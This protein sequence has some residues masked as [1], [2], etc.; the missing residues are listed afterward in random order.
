ML[1][2]EPP[3]ALPGQAALASAASRA[4]RPIRLLALIVLL[5]GC[6]TVA[7]V[8]GTA[9][10]DDVAQLR[11]DVTALQLGFQRLRVDSER[12][13]SQLDTRV[14]EQTAVT[15][16]QAEELSQQLDRLSTTVT[17]LTARLDQ[18]SG[19][20]DAL[21]QRATMQPPPR[22]RAQ[23]A[24]PMQRPVPGPSTAVPA[25][26]PQAIPAPPPQAALPGSTPATPPSAATRPTTGPLEPQDIYQ[27][28][29][30][31]FSK[32]SYQ[33]AIEGFRE[34]LRRFPDHELAGNAQYWIGEAYFSVARGQTDAGQAEPAKRSLEQAVQ[35]YRKV[36]VN[37]PRGDKAPTA[38]YKEALALVDLKQP[39]LAQ[40]RLQYLIENFPQA[41]EAPLAR[42]KLASLKSG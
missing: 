30:L 29:Y 18:V 6:S 2:Q 9:T 33:R 37:Y 3:R 32:G 23:A 22:P 27:A 36:I 38:L 39:A 15:Q 4:G 24:A 12:Q 28:A 7:D 8:T 11:A 14:R 20:L 40:Q 19:K 21:S 16:R 25:P 35:E 42:E 31:D 10:L 13:A 5:A 1:E 26:P 17:A 41:E 34:F